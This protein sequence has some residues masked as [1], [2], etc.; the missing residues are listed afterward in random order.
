MTTIAGLLIGLLGAATAAA[1]FAPAGSV[2]GVE[3]PRRRFR[4]GRV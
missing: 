2:H 3:C 4:T 1:A